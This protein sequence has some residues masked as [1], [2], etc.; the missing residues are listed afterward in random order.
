MGTRVPSSLHQGSNSYLVLGGVLS[1]CQAQGVATK[2]SN[3]YWSVSDR[4]QQI[5][6]ETDDM[7]CY[8]IANNS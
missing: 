2:N 7:I 6:F 5:T 4:T 8:S 3:S 1:R